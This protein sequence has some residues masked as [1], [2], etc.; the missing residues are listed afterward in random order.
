MRIIVIDPDQNCRW[1]P[2]EFLRPAQ[3]CSPHSP[4]RSPHV[5]AAPSHDIHAVQYTTKVI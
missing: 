4:E 3:I 5:C 1:I 2:V